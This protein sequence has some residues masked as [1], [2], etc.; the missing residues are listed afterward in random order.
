MTF[1][2]PNSL[3]LAAP[4]VCLPFL[5]PLLLHGG[6]AH[7]R[8]GAKKEKQPPRL[9]LQL[10]TTPPCLA[11]NK[12]ESIGPPPPS[13][14][15]CVLSFS[16]PGGSTF[17]DKQSEKTC[18]PRVLVELGGAP[19]TTRRK[20]DPPPQKTKNFPLFSTQKV[21]PPPFDLQKPKPARKKNGEDA[22]AAITFQYDP[23]KHQ[24]H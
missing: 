6:L 1:L 21:P 2:V 5:N 20:L 15:S 17:V 3:F 11:A 23:Q 24:K 10:W 7:L 9:S 14:P 22:R 19:S 4:P 8:V 16:C 18:P 12:K 13:P